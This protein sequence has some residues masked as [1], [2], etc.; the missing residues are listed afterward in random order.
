[1][2]WL[3]AMYARLRDQSGQTLAEYGLVV[4]SIAIVVVLAA[5]LLGVNITDLFT[6]SSHGI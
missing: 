4:V 6:K 5:A 3:N 1:M 2:E